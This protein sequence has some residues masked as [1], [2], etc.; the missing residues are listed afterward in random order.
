ME[1]KPLARALYDHC[2]VGSAVPSAV[3]S[4]V[5]EL[6]AFVYQMQGTLAQKAEQNRNRIVSQGGKIDQEVPI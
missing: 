6:L 5:A 2:P 4:A 3:F 1:N